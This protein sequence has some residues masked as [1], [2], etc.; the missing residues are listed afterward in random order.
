MS[1]TYSLY[2]FLQQLVGDDGLRADFATDPRATLAEH[3][4]DGLGPEDVRD[5]LVLV[6]DT[7]TTD[8]DPDHA[9][10]DAHHDLPVFDGADHD[11]VQ[12][13]NAYVAQNGGADPAGYDLEHH[14]DVDD[15]S[16]A[17]HLEVSHYDDPDLHGLDSPSFGAGYAGADAAGDD[18]L[19][20]PTDSGDDPFAGHG[21]AQAAASYDDP[22]AY[23]DLDDQT[24]HGTADPFPD[25]VGHSAPEPGHE[26]PGHS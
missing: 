17:G 6:E 3:G 5:A 8:F 14:L 11:A 26:A 16:V 13:L 12:Y 9:T 23:D 24:G 15:V 1:E 19:A 2:E 4:L 25:H 10:A 18:H 20:G 22:G 21:A 7:R